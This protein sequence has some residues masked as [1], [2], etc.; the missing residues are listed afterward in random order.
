MAG[1]LTSCMTEICRMYTGN[2]NNWDENQAHPHIPNDDTAQR[3][4]S[5]LY[6]ATAVVLPSAVSYLCN[7]THCC[8][9]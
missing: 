3:M 5:Y 8:V 6:H 4:V 2:H 9:L 1:A 7:G